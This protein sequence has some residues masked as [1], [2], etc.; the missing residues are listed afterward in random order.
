MAQILANGQIKVQSGDTLYKIAQQVYGDGSRWKELGFGG[1]PTKLAVG[2]VLT[3]PS[4][5]SSSSL[6]DSKLKSLIYQ[7]SGGTKPNPTSTTPKASVTP[8]SALGSTNISLTPEQKANQFIQN[9]ID[10]YTKPFL[11]AQARAKAFDEKNPFAFDEV[12]A[13]QSATE[14]LD[15]YYKAQIQDYTIGVERSKGRTIED[16]KTLIND[17]NTSTERQKTK[18]EI[19]LDR[20]IRSSENGYAAGN[21]FFSGERLRASGE[22]TADTAFNNQ[23]LDINRNNAALSAETNQNRTLEDLASGQQ[24]FNRNLKAA[25]ETA[26][27]SDV[28][29]QKK[30]AL[31]ARELQRQAAIGFPYVSG[32]Q[33]VSSVY[34]LS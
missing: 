8:T 9:T 6:P 26:L 33:S 29:Q 32:S 2:T 34:G 17:L 24:I 25:E 19:S 30:D 3:P 4:A 5:S 15:P 16:T 13:R 18:N 14:R 21:T 23:G 7:S 1:D 28:N 27:T 10:S 12:L 20:A 11:D 22:N 31:Q